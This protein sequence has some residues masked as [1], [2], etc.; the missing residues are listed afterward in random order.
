MAD[1]LFLAL[2]IVEPANILLVKGN[3]FR[4]FQR[5]ANRAGNADFAQLRLW[6]HRATA[7]SG[8]F[9]P[10][11]T[12][13][14]ASR[15]IA[16]LKT[17]D[18]PF[19]STAQARRLYRA[20]KA[21]S[22]YSFSSA[23]GIWSIETRAPATFRSSALEDDDWYLCVEDGFVARVPGSSV[24]TAMQLLPWLNG[25]HTE[26]EIRA[27]IVGCGP[28]ETLFELFLANGCLRPVKRQ[29]RAIDRAPDFVF[30]GH[31]AMFVRGKTSSIVIDPALSAT[32]RGRFD[33]RSFALVG[34]ADAVLLTHHHWDHT[35]PSTLLR[36]ARD[37]RIYVP[38][39]RHGTFANP[40]LRAYLKLWGFTNVREV[41]PWDRVE[42]GD[43]A[44]TFAPSYGEPFG[45]DSRFDAFGV[46]AE[47][48]GRKLYSSGDACNDETTGMDETN[49]RIAKRGID[50]F[51]CGSS[52]LCWSPPAMAGW[53]RKFSNELLHRPE[54]IRYHPTAR[55][56]ARWISMLKPKAF[57][58]IAA[59]VWAG[60]K[61]PTVD[62]SSSSDHG[63]RFAAYRQDIERAHPQDN[64]VRA[65][66]A[67]LA[68][69]AERVPV[70]GLHP[71]QGMR[72][73]R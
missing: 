18:T 65:W 5:Y 29:V 14:V 10:R 40:P 52:G 24:S 1:P 12:I 57:I 46:I 26:A 63:R 23:K 50:Y 7:P 39:C 54:L 60:V 53:Y 67:S 41:D 9:F 11:G 2:G 3:D 17:L 62:L 28:Q 70:V 66:M 69:L 6:F 61:R 34:S 47:F 56:A 44:L 16:E 73:R 37:K 71:L 27:A 22:M 33:P 72:T 32:E 8:I 38:R 4:A 36:I 30:L 45:I 42:V 58:P 51:A 68:A 59:F 13:S 43:V 20:C 64:E 55:D 35:N 49:D 31:S 21:R 19:P 48:G 25:T 15:I